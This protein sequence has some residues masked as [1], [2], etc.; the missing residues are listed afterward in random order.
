MRFSIFCIIVD[1]HP[2]L[3]LLLKV[4]R[5]TIQSSQWFNLGINLGLD[6]YSLMVIEKDYKEVE[7]C[8]R[9]MLAL[10]LRGPEEGCTKQALL[11]AMSKINFVGKFIHNC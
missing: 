6:Y 2:H 5:S 4:L 1:V 10:W 7:E 8:M 11:K 3:L 9:E